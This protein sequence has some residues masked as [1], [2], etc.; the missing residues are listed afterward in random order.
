MK[1]I[2]TVFRGLQFNL[3]NRKV[4]KSNTILCIYYLILSAVLTCMH[5]ILILALIATFGDVN[6]A[7]ERI[8]S[9]AQ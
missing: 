4:F 1:T 6:A 2:A 9:H 8:L 5:I 7:V 3:S